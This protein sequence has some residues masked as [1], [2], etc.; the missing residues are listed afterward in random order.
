MGSSAVQPGTPPP[1][2]SSVDDFYVPAYQIVLNGKK[3]PKLVQDI[4]SL[5]FHDSLTEVDSVDLVVNN[6][7]PGEPVQGQA[8]QGKFRYHNTNLLDPGQDVEVKMGY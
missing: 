7:D 8:V 2:L 4:L 1:Q 6:W 3:D 5:T